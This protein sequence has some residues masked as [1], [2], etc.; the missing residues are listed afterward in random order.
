MKSKILIIL[1]LAIA[2]MAMA[3]K[4]PIPYEWFE[5]QSKII[6]DLQYK[7]NGQNKRVYAKDNVTI[8]YSD[9]LASW[10]WRH[11][12]NGI[13][14]LHIAEDIDFSK[15]IGLANTDNI[16]HVTFAHNSITEQIYGGKENQLLK[17]SALDFYTNSETD[18]AE[19]LFEL[20][21]IIT[22]LKVNKGLV[23]RTDMVNQWRDYESLKPYEFYQK[24]P[25]SILAL[26]AILIKEELA[27]KEAE[28]KKRKKEEMLKSVA[29]NMVLVQGGTFNMGSKN[30]KDEKPVH[31]VT[32]STFS[33]G[34]YPVTVG[35]YKYYCEVTGKKMP[36]STPNWGWHDNHPMVYV[37]WNEAVSY[38]KWLGR[39]LGGIWRLSTEAEWEY[40]ARGGN[41]SK[42]FKYSGSNKLNDV[43]WHSR[44][45]GFK[46]NPVGTKQPNE[47]GLYD[48]S[49]N[50]LEWCSDWY[51]SKYYASSPSVSPLGPASGNSYVL[52]GAGWFYHSAGFFS[53]THR[54]IGSPTQRNSYSGFRVVRVE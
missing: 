43:A 8:N 48:M 9:Q 23:T 14:Y 10:S 53:T 46:T 49:G 16:V 25:K 12:V 28:I 21:H 6:S 5:K 24:Y 40:A 18:C 33:I 50:V 22:E 13:E 45:S 37:T 32:L 35:Q 47:L 4:E 34:K 31:A 17:L 41:Q 30:R 36:P 27:R 15:V 7:A 42:G 51:S 1:F 39:E 26:K 3:Q 29:A 20:Y 2:N 54:F 19:M 44:N 38:A 11:T 52:R